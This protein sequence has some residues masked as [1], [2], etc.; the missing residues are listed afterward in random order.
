[1]PT[2]KKEERFKI[3]N[4]TLKLRELEKEEQTKPRVSERKEIILEQKSMK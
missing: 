1:M 3:N 2:L 4:L